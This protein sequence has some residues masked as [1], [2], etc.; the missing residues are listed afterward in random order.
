MPRTRGSKAGT[1]E[2]V[3][4]G[5]GDKGLSLN[6]Y[7][8]DG[9]ALLAFDID[10]KLAQDLAGFAIECDPP[11]GKP[12][13][14]LNRLSFAQEITAKTTPAEREWTPT[15][16]APIQKFHWVDYPPQVTKGK[17][18]YTAT[19]MRFKKG[20]EQEIEAGPSGEVSLDLWDEGYGNFDLGFT[21]GYLS[22]QAYAERFHNEPVE[23]TP[24]T[25]DFD[26]KP[27]AERYSWLGSHAGKLVFELLDETVADPKLSLDVFAYDFNEPDVIRKMEALGSRL[28]LYLDNSASHVAAKDDKTPP[29]EVAALAAITK[30]AG[31]DNVQVGHF[32]RFAHDKI[33]IQKRDD[34]PVKVLSGSANFS[35]RGLYVQSNNVFVFDDP[36]TAEIYGEAFNQAWTDAGHFSKSAI[37]SAWFP[38]PPGKDPNLPNFQVSFAPHAD[39]SVSLEPVA[40]AIKGAKSSVLFAIMEIGSGSGAVL[41]AVRGLPNRSELYAFGT[42]QRLDGGLDVTSPGK[43]PVFIPFSYLHSKVPAPFQAEISG[44][45]GQVI[46]HKFVVVDFNGPSPA[47]FAGS[48]NLAAG[49]EEANGDNLLAFRDPAICSTYAVE[50]IRL[51]DHYRFRAAMQGATEAAPLQLKSHSED[52]SKDYFD[53][54]SAKCREREVF[55]A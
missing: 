22:S 51:I 31:K 52:W 12:Y 37:A 30:S 20:S 50:A 15:S 33:L 41:D 28:R 34:K 11:T 38:D 54:K 29:R 2:H 49:G 21:R 18:T 8:G 7:R 45:M 47:V 44:G 32:H 5:S 39:A 46:H 19:A 35:V 43:D 27:Y 14:L 25:I 23:P 16:E 4:K 9:S 48:S 40:E 53:P 10:P 3:V 1:G 55:V 36:A 13:P 17:F 24:A 6:V 26:T 42:T